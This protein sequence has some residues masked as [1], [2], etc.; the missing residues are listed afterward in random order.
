[1]PTVGTTSAPNSPVRATSHYDLAA[2]VRLNLS[3]KIDINLYGIYS[4]LND[5]LSFFLDN[6]Y[7]LNNVFT[8]IYDSL[9][10]IKLGGNFVFLNDEMLRLEAK[11][12][13]YIYRNKRTQLHGDVYRP[14]PLY[15]RPDFDAGICATANYHDK[16]IGRL[17]FQLLGRTYATAP[18]FD[19][20]ASRYN[21]PMRYGLN[22]EVEYRH[23]KALSFFLKADNLLFQRYYY[24]QNYPSYRGLFLLGLT[25]T[26]PN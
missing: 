8:P 3:K 1:M 2:K 22:M 13:Y 23:N 7:H 25:Y 4:N 24:W 11:G 20:S 5:D 10:R 16:I 18:A 19:G 26:I 9:T 12:N 17:E 14:L 21:L 15:Y 6:R